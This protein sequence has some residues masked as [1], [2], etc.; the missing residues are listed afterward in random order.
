MDPVTSLE[1]WKTDGT[2]AGT[3][4]VKDIAPGAGYS[5]PYMLADLNGVLIFLAYDQADGFHH[6]WRSDGTVGGTWRVSVLSFGFSPGSSR[7]AVAADRVYFVAYSPM[8][9][10]SLWRTD[11]TAS[12]TAVVYAAPAVNPTLINGTLF[13]AGYDAIH[14]YELWKSDGINVTFIKDI[15]PGTEWGVSTGDGSFVALDG[16][17]LF[18]ANANGLWRSDGTTEGTTAVLSENGETIQY[19]SQFVL[20]DNGSVVFS[21]CTAAAG[22]ELF[23]LNAVTSPQLIGDLLPGPSSS[24]PY[25]VTSAGA[26]AVFSTAAS[27]GSELWRSD[28][29]VSGTI[30]VKDLGPDTD[31][32]YISGLTVGNGWVF[33]SADDGIHGRELWRSDGRGPGTSMVA[34]LAAGAESSWV[35][36]VAMVNSRLVLLRWTLNGYELWAYDATAVVPTPTGSGIAISPTTTLPGGSTVPVSITF[37]TVTGAGETTVTTSGTGAPPPAGFKLSNP[38]VY[39]E[40][41]TTAAFT[42][43][44]SVCLSWAEGQVANESRVRMFHHDGNRWVDITD[45]ASLDTTNNR[46]CGTTSSFSPFA[47]METKYPFTGFFQP[48]DNLPTTNAVKAGAAV[49]VKFSLGGNRGL[50]VLASASPLLVQCSTGATI[51]NIEETVTAGGSSLNYD[52]ASG[53]Y[54]YIWKTDK[55]WAGSCRELQLKLDDG[56]VYRARFTFSR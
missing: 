6:V 48:V 24:S 7:V 56:E 28:G 52:A 15:T 39:Y 34:D 42:G 13:F 18:S 30:L 32:S 1:L 49:P 9:G 43:T 27:A 40:I 23:T 54:A 17:L 5:T 3:Q 41:S 45:A 37:S 55:L 51:D 33:F 47:L 10:W 53:Q 50:N 12:G 31:S 36:P 44:V 2:S 22:C 38:P 8:H 29:T 11:G 14:G 19:P 21:G 35:E 4:I 46:V 20:L 26:F 25:G 16:A